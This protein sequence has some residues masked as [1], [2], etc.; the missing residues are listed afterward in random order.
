MKVEDLPLRAPHVVRILNGLQRLD[1]TGVS[2]L[3]PFARRRF[4][5]LPNMGHKSVDELE[6]AL[7]EA[8]VMTSAGVEVKPRL[9]LEMDRATK[10]RVDSI[11][12]RE[13]CSITEA[14]RRG[15]R[16]Y[17]MA[18][19]NQDRGGTLLLRASDEARAVGVED[20]EVVL[21]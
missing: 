12:E 2:Q 16:L 20:K 11:R 6:R 14:I 15:M 9:N 10:D 13:G 19:A 21:F 18:L 8:N 17:E 5:R 4:L 1:I 7:I 3:L